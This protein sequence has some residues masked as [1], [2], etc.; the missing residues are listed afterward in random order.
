M[1]VNKANGNPVYY[2]ADGSLVQGNIANQN[3]YVFDSNNPND[4]SKVSNLVEGDKRILGNT[5]PTYFGSINTTLRYG[6]FDFSAMIRFSG[7][8][9]ISNLTRRDVGYGFYKQ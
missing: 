6:N 9:K 5:L 4:L 3:Y 2:K 7:G 1:G 8:N